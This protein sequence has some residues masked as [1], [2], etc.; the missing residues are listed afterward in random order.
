MLMMVHYWLGLHEMTNL[1]NDSGVEP[2]WRESLCII[3]VVKTRNIKRSCLGHVLDFI[4]SAKQAQNSFFNLKYNNKIP[5]N[6]DV[7]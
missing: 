3:S 2:K 6:I 7:S 1:G 4:L 5:F